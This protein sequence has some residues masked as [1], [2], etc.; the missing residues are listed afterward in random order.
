MRDWLAI[1]AE[2][3]KVQLDGLPQLG[4]DCVLGTCQCDAAGRSGHHAPYPPSL[5]R[6][7]TTA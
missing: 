4:Q 1:F 2:P 6:S 3:G 5:A 7:I